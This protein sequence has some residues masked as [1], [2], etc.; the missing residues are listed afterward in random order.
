MFKVQSY[1]I[2]KPKRRCDELGRRSN[3]FLLELAVAAGSNKKWF[4]IQNL[5]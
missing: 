3:L 5:E 4:Q 1:L 2:Q